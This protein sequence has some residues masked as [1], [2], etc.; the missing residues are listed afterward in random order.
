[1]NLWGSCPPT[2]DKGE[3]IG[4]DGEIAFAA[5]MVAAEEEVEIADVVIGVDRGG[6]APRPPTVRGPNTSSHVRKRPV[7]VVFIG[8]GLLRLDWVLLV[9]LVVLFVPRCIFSF[10]TGIVS[11]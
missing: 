2:L 10:T 8:F 3:K 1:L 5:V 7:R 9:V 6:S 11:S 4:L